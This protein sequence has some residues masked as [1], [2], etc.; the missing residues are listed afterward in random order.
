M[1]SVESAPP[2]SP[3]PPD[4]EAEPQQARPE[5]AGRVP[6]PEEVK[7]FVE[8]K[9]A[10]VKTRRCHFGKSCKKK[11]TCYLIHDDSSS[12][13]TRA[14][15]LCEKYW[16][17]LASKFRAGT[18]SRF[19]TP[20]NAF[21]KGYCADP[22][23]GFL[24]I[25]PKDALDS[26]G[27][28]IGRFQFNKPELAILSR[29]SPSDSMKIQMEIR[30]Y[31]RFPCPL[32]IKHGGKCKEG[33][34]CLDKHDETREELDALT[35]SRFLEMVR[36]AEATY[37]RTA[38]CSFLEN[39]GECRFGNHCIYIH[40][41]EEDSKRREARLAKHRQVDEQDSRNKAPREN[42]NA[43]E[44][45]AACG[46]C[47][48]VICQAA[49]IAM[50]VVEGAFNVICT[51]NKFRNACLVKQH[52]K[53]GSLKFKP[54][55]I[56][57]NACK[58]GLGSVV[59]FPKTDY[60]G[61]FWEAKSIVFLNVKSH[62][63]IETRNWWQWF[64]ILPRLSLSKAPPLKTVPTGVDPEKAFAA[65]EPK[66]SVV[67]HTL[68]KKVL[69]T[70][71]KVD[72]IDGAEGEAKTGEAEEKAVG[73]QKDGE[74]QSVGGEG[75]DSAMSAVKDES[76][77]HEGDAKEVKEIEVVQEV[78]EDVEILQDRSVVIEQQEYERLMEAGKKPERTDSDDLELLKKR[79]LNELRE[80]KKELE[81]RLRL[82]EILEQLEFYFGIENLVKDKWMK[83]QISSNR[84]QYVSL[85]KI[86]TF[87]KMQQLNANPRDCV[88]AV[89]ELG[90]PIVEVSPDGYNIRRKVHFD[91]D[92][93]AKTYERAIYVD[94]IPVGMDYKQ[95][96]EA[97]ST[98]GTVTD[99]RVSKDHLK[100]GIPAT[101]T[102]YFKDEEGYNAAMKAYRVPLAVIMKPRGWKAK[103]CETFMRGGKCERPTPDC[104]RAHGEGDL[105]P[106][107]KPG[108]SY[109]AVPWLTYKENEKKFLRV[110]AK[111]LEKAGV[112]VDV[113]GGRGRGRAWFSQR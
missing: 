54:F 2:N 51:T 57:C 6:T 24:H 73:E 90:S 105:W 80:K 89:K 43:E 64:G 75:E 47:Y 45:V 106:K 85:E 107:P 79:G 36:K 81:A 27:R 4:P 103:L 61:P 46:H 87:K 14:K 78:E 99:A 72:R 93:M 63:P 5:P 88:S 56:Y 28:V 110:A 13:F 66:E 102:V 32:F 94:R 68:R 8:R 12:E 42:F 55:K 52:H 10:K 101:G 53:I 31:K 86:C 112:I 3:P 77:V 98:F 11:A 74:V 21:L 62:N 76:K 97:F 38:K 70:F 25:D 58:G 15:S 44:Y 104:P 111:R 100:A 7:D 9:W 35:R 96:M 23:C 39:K 48:S 50:S 84:E 34:H 67:L 22:F 59:A 40:N 95:L 49:D 92:D 91:P 29:V 82:R 30:E 60:R 33:L 108:P 41:P 109:V 26:K 17:D 1:A 83:E 16:G 113:G 20:C 69:Q 65:V 37:F 19:R 18:G 71:R